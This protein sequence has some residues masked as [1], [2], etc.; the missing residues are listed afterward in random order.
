VGSALFAWLLLRGRMIPVSLA[1][2]GVA[3]SAA[4]VAILIVQR[5]G[6]FGSAV[7]WASSMTWI[8][9]FPMLV[10][11]VTLALWLVV[12]GVSGPIERQAT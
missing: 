4:L 12:K 3:A 2:L 5:A 8:V 10:F 7:S 6:F 9:W 1:W 11:E